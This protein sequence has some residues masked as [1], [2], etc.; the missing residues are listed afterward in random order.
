MLKPVSCNFLIRPRISFKEEAFSI[1]YFLYGNMSTIS[2]FCL[3]LFG[4]YLP[5]P[6]KVVQNP[7]DRSQFLTPQEIRKVRFCFSLKKKKVKPSA[8]ASSAEHQ[9]QTV[10]YLSTTAVNSIDR[11]LY[12]F[13][14]VKSKR[15]SR[16]VKITSDDFVTDCL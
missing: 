4:T 6:T 11:F 12:L 16:S 5:F 14:S 3:G 10:L 13:V 2:A 9:I 1:I 15:R 8:T 7:M